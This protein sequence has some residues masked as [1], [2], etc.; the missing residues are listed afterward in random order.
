M[1][2]LRRLV[3]NPL[4][5]MRFYRTKY[6]IACTVWKLSYNTA[7]HHQRICNLKI[8][9]YRGCDISGLKTC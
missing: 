1:K 9:F 4:L 8:L 7:I 5:R 3:T 6:V 2:H